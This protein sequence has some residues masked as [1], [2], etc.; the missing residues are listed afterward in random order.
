MILLLPTA[1]S[2]TSQSGRDR[3]VVREFE[4]I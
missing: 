4:I 2:G 3:Q 1:R